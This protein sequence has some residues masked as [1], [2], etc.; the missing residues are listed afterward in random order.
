METKLTSDDVNILKGHIP[1]LDGF[2]GLALCVAVL[3]HY[4]SCTVTT[5]NAPMR[6]LRPL[7]DLSVI[8]VDSFFVLSGFLIAS[9][10][11]RSKSSP[12]YFTSFYAR[13]VLRIF[14]MYYML[15]FLFIAGIWCGG[16][17]KIPYL[18]N[19]PL[20]L[21][22]YAVF[23][24]NFFMSVVNGQYNFGPH[25]LGI[26]WS[27]SIEEQFYFVM[28]FL[29]WL[30]PSKH[31]IKTC[32]I[33]IGTCWAYKWNF[34]NDLM[35][36][37]VSMP[38]RM[39]SLVM[40]I[41]IAYG[42]QQEEFINKVKG[43]L[44]YLRPALVAL[45]IFLILMIQYF[46]GKSWYVYLFSIAGIMYSICLLIILIN[47]QGFLSR[48]FNFS[49]FRWLG[50]ISFSVYLFHQAING[51]FHQWILNQAPTIHIGE[52]D[53]VWKDI[54]VTLLSATCTILLAQFTYHKM[55]KPL[56]KYGHKKFTY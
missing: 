1:Q 35:S 43:I 24:Q 17:Q 29:I 21:W 7:T 51:A 22:S 12:G 15:Y 48:F 5:Y 28:P 34:R 2:R 56:I 53:L 18:F 10:L 37:Y 25:F 40:G 14:P 47:R 39:D 52:S 45:L 31:L 23:V 19:D 50:R 54:L 11:L 4:Y 6:I 36:V 26:T 13:R 32:I 55:E 16:A 20:P 49:I 42:M 8:C 38:G 30:V 46:S 44:Y 3:W 41:M 33:L 9:I 27:V